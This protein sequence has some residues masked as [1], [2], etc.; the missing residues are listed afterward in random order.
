MNSKK[1]KLF[2]DHQIF[3]LQRTGGISRYYT[4]LINRAKKN[5]EVDL[6]FPEYLSDNQYLN[7]RPLPYLLDRN[8]PGKNRI[9]NSINQFKSYGILRSNQ[10][11]IIHPTY[12]DPYVVKVKGSAGLVITVYDM[13]H[14]KFSELSSEGLV[15][16]QKKE[17]V[18][19]SDLIIAI[20]ESTK[21]DLIE[22]LNVNPQKIRVTYLASSLPSPVTFSNS[23]GN[24]P[25]VLFVG[26]RG[27]Y[28]N[29]KFFITAFSKLSPKRDLTVLCV[30]GGRSPIKKMIVSSR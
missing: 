20:S 21:K 22:I 12:Y 7:Q 4:E 2:Y 14:E 24:V 17:M 28:K 15:S 11:N 19:K 5:S 8:F 10:F 18:K 3:S 29:F 6:V 25:Y 30:G 13:I 23:L 1:I 16:K 27:G 9:V 26:R